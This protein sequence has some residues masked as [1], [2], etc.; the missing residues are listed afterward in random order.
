VSDKEVIIT[1]KEMA[2][3]VIIRRA[4]AKLTL[5]RFMIEFEDRLADYI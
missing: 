2:I 5:N 3:E 4:H 1:F